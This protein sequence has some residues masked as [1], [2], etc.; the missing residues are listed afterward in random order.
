MTKYEKI[1]QFL[2]N[3]WGVTFFTYKGK[4]LQKTEAGWV[5]V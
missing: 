4:K 2:F 1:G 5:Y 3:T